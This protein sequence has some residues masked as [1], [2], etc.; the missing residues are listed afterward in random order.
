M[1]KLIFSMFMFILMFTFS[2]KKKAE[3]KVTKKKNT[4]ITVKSDY[5]LKP[6]KV[7]QE[8]INALSEIFSFGD[9]LLKERR[10]IQKKIQD[11][12][13][14]FKDF[15][16][17][18]TLKK[19][20]PYKYTRVSY[21][22]TSV[23]TTIYAD[24]KK[25]EDKKLFWI[26][27]SYRFNLNKNERSIYKDDFEGFKARHL[28]DEWVWILLDNNI[29]IKIS[30]YSDKTK[31]DEELKKVLKSFDTEAMKNLFAKDSKN[32][33]LRNYLLKIK[34]LNSKI[35]DINKKFSEKEKDAVKAL[36]PFLNFNEG[37]LKG[38]DLNQ[39]RY[40]ISNT[41]NIY[42]KKNR[43]SL[44]TVYIGREA[45]ILGAANFFNRK[46]AKYGNMGNFKYL[47][48]EDRTVM[49]KLPSLIVKIN[50]FYKNEYRNKD[51]LMKIMAEFDLIGLSK[52][53]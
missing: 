26:I 9:N 42:A 50:T 21:F 30:A 13:K 7:T 49:V 17:V 28:K 19:D 18:F 44:F 51:K 43:K 4:K 16:A 48:I 37:V 53:K 38:I 11:L 2:C 52:V 23:W 40:N 27:V 25:E 33:K 8:Q 5:N 46:D 6:S 41:F 47:S 20:S 35:M 34:E 36:K 12:A 14:N 32:A 31:K 22:P 1:K 29:E 3:N 45:N 24:E 39:I 10:K 15:G